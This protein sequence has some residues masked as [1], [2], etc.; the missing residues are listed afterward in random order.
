MTTAGAAAKED[1]RQAA[2]RR[3]QK[4]AP[5]ARAKFAARLADEG[6]RLAKAF[7]AR[8]VSAFFPLPDEP[9]AR[10][11][12]AALA[13]AGF[14]TLLPVTT[15]LGA[16]LVF[17]AWRPGEPTKLGKMK[18]AEP[19][20]S[21]KAFDPDL[22]FV[23]LACFDRR[24]HRIGYGAGYYDRTLRALRAK[25]PAIAV[26]VAFGVSEC[27]AAPFAAHDERLDFVLTDN[28]LIDC[29]GD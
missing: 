24:G 16:A 23:P 29:R 4:L 3:R 8:R 17:R 13:E 6:L 14:L 28:E 7:S 21:A 11:L 15:P 26:G 12:L 22:L 5:A 10:P 9:D 27:A 1:L 25:G 20:E 19:Q 18:I 2:L